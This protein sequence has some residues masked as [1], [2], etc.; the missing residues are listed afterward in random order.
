MEIGHTLLVGTV[1][2]G[3]EQFM[4]MGLSSRE[5]EITKS[6]YDVDRKS[7]TR[8]SSFQCPTL[9]WDNKN[10]CCFVCPP[11]EANNAQY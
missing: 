5:I 2:M 6:R 3:A 4:S 1:H 10:S 8:Y 9:V 11:R 7:S